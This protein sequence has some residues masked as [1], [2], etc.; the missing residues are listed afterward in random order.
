MN[1]KLNR[2]VPVYF[3]I[4]GILISLGI[5]VLDYILTSRPSSGPKLLGLNLI[6]P[7]IDLGFLITIFVLMRRINREQVR[8]HEELANSERELIEASQGKSEI[9]SILSHDL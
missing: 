8:R 3:L 5:D 7:M 2:R 9:L 6:E 4:A 1:S